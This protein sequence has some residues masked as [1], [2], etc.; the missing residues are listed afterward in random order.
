MLKREF[1]TL[2]PDADDTTLE[3]LVF[4][5]KGIVLAYGHSRRLL[6][7]DDAVGLLDRG[8]ERDIGVAV[9]G[10]P[11]DGLAADD[12]GNP[13]PRIGFLQRQRPGIHHPVLVMRAFPAEGAW[14]RPGFHDEVMRLLEPLLT[15]SDVDRVYVVSATHE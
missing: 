7:D 5:F 4:Q 13:D 1:R 6:D 10:R 9:P 2:T 12:A 15:F 3:V 14:L 8:I 11:D